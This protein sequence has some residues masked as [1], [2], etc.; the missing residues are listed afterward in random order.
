MILLPILKNKHIMTTLEYKTLIFPP[1]LFYSLQEF[2]E[3]IKIREEGWK[4]G[5]ENVLKVCIKNELYEYCAL[6]KKE[7]DKGV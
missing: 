2:E 4:E 6:I 1:N 7:L 5:L 3:F